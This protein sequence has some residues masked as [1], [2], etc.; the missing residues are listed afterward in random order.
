MTPGVLAPDPKEANPDDVPVLVDAG[1]A[2]AKLDASLDPSATAGGAVDAES[3]VPC[4]A[5]VG[6]WLESSMSIP[7]APFAAAA[8]TAGIAAADVEDDGLP[9]LSLVLGAA[10]PSG[11]HRSTTSL[12]PARPVPPPIGILEVGAGVLDPPAADAAAV[13]EDAIQL[14]MVPCAVAVAGFEAGAGAGA[15]LYGLAEGRPAELAYGLAAPPLL[16]PLEA[17]GLEKVDDEDDDE[18]AAVDGVGRATPV[19]LFAC[20]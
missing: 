11:L 16:P 9:T 10:E 1:V 12:P 2:F 5:V 4:S 20:C 19:L 8:R 15:E 18:V 3:C 13:A 6:P 7:L 14:D 17:Y